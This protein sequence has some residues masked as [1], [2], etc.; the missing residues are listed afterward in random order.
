LVSNTS[1]RLKTPVYLSV[2]G[3]SLLAANYHGSDNTT[4]PVGAGITA[5]K[6]SDGCALTFAGD[7]PTYGHSVNPARQGAS[8]IHSVVPDPKYPGRFYA[9]DLGADFVITWVALMEDG[10]K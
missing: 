3:Q 1:T 5:F 4:V 9:C 8:H 6:V 10:G 2:I 7:M